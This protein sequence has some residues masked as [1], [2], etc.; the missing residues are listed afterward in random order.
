MNKNTYGAVAALTL[1]VVI[2][3]IVPSLI[4]SFALETGAADSIVIRMCTNAVLCLPLMPLAGW[5]I[6]KSDWPRLIILSCVCNFGYYAGSIFGFANLSAGAGGMLYATNPL[7]IM[8]L[9][10]AIGQERLS[11]P[12]VLGASISFIGTLY[13]FSNGLDSGVGGNPLF[14][15][16]MMLA[17]C[18]GWALYAVFMKPLVQKYG[19]LK[20]TLYSTMLPALPSLFF[21]SAHTYSTFTHMSGNAIIAL[22]TMGLLGTILGVI[23]WNYA[24]THLSASSTGISL[25]MI[26]PGVALFGWLFL[27]ETTG[28]QTLLGGFIIMIGVAV[29]EFGKSFKL[30]R[31]T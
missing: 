16:V 10:V 4:R 31:A 22:L 30:A 12:V 19:P 13:L 14:G 11:A 3:G 1:A 9:A 18:F 5:R 8:A 29:A 28:P 26:P 21:Y 2:W 23:L 25:Y 6:E 15:G 17:G 20:I 27:G 7:M 24:S